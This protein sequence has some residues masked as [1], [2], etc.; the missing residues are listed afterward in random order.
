MPRFGQDSPA[1]VAEN[2]SQYGEGDAEQLTPVQLEQSRQNRCAQGTGVRQPNTEACEGNKR[3]QQGRAERCPTRGAR[4]RWG[5]G[6]P[7]SPPAKGRRTDR[8]WWRH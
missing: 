8:R 4:P 6:G 7:P 2:Q 3:Q 1:A 5:R